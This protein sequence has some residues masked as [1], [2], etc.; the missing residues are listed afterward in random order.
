M[1]ATTK[2]HLMLFLHSKNIVC[3]LRLF[4]LSNAVYKAEYTHL[5]SCRGSL[6]VRTSLSAAQVVSQRVSLW[7]VFEAEAEAEAEALV[8][9]LYI[10]SS[11]SDFGISSVSRLRIFQV[12]S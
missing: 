5:I 4:H 6:E 1:Y 2:P 9:L 11:L 12:A 8:C 3:P 7:A 10:R